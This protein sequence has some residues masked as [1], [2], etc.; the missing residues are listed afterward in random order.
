[1]AELTNKNINGKNK[2]E[3]TL[4]KAKKYLNLD[5]MNNSNQYYRVDES[6]PIDDNL[7]LYTGDDWK[8]VDTKYGRKVYAETDNAG[9][10]WLT[11]WATLIVKV[12]N[13]HDFM[14]DAV[15]FKIS[16]KQ[17]NYELLKEKA[18][19]CDD[20]WTVKQWIA[21]KCKVLVNKKHGFASSVN[22]DDK[23]EKVGDDW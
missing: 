22:I 18:I 7:L 5:L 16:P 19:G 9:E 6:K 4:N 1:M 21:D 12:V 2:A 14:K 11:D 3:R 15:L 10:L 20:I 8:I 13:T 23:W 17:K